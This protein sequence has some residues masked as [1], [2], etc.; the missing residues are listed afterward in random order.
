VS[1]DKKMK[2]WDKR[3]QFC[4][5]SIEAHVAEIMSVDYSPFE[6]NLVITG[7]ADRSVAVWDTRN[8][9]TKLFSL[10]KH[11]DEVNQVK[12]S[13]HACNLL[14]SG[15]SDRTVVIWDLSRIGMDHQLTEEEKK[16]GPAEC[17]F[18][19]GGHTA[20]IS[21]LSWNLNER[22][23]LASVAEDNIL[24]VWQPAWEKCKEL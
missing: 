15:S 6:A 18:I 4:G 12:F 24:Q 13:R 5:Q 14:A 9:K 1:D 17:V 3:Q 11:T 7:S 21:D 20:K 19:H 10:R 23:M 22:V 16:D 2:I 8:L